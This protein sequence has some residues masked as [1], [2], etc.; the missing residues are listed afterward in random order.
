MSGP[1]D[2][3]IAVVK[4]NVV[5]INAPIFVQNSPTCNIQWKRSTYSRFGETWDSFSQMDHELFALHRVDKDT[6]TLNVRID[7]LFIC[8]VCIEAL[9]AI[10]FT[11]YI[12]HLLPLRS[13]HDIL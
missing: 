8:P 6:I 3:M 11:S 4:D 12:L 2:K 5:T 1:G 9:A 7:K 13:S 10:S